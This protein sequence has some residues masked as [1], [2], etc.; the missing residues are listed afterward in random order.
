MIL[1]DCAATTSLIAW[2]RRQLGFAYGLLLRDRPT[3]AI[4]VAGDREQPRRVVHRRVP[5]DSVSWSRIREGV[6]GTSPE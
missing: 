4:V 3:I 5:H 2:V 6:A 1:A